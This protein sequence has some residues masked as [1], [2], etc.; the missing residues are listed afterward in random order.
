VGVTWFYADKRTN[1]KEHQ[2]IGLISRVIK[3][4]HDTNIL[5]MPGGKGHEKT[6][7][8][9]QRGKP[10]HLSTLSSSFCCQPLLKTELSHCT[11]LLCVLC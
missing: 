3:S 2:I 1:Y 8:L 6:L 10:K 4:R 9:K 5:H 11:I 7:E